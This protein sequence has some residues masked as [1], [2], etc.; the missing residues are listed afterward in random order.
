MKFIVRRKLNLLNQT[1]DLA[2][3][4]AQ[5]L[6]AFETAETQITNLKFDNLTPHTGSTI[7]GIDTAVPTDPLNAARALTGK[8]NKD[9][10]YILANGET[11]KAKQLYDDTV[12]AITLICNSQSYQI[13][14]YTPFSGAPNWAMKDNLSA[15]DKKTC[16]ATLPNKIP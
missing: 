13:I 5:A 14:S 16:L 2:D 9:I 11:D 4:K 1:I 3:R 8:T 10:P 15:T 7:A 6:T 12:A